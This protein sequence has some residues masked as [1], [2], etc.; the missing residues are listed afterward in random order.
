MCLQLSDRWASSWQHLA[1][2]CSV[3]KV[4]DCTGTM[5]LTGQICTK[6]RW[7]AETPTM[8]PN[9]PMTN[10]ALYVRFYFLYECSLMYCTRLIVEFS[11]VRVTYKLLALHRTQGFTMDSVAGPACP[12]RRQHPHLSSGSWSLLS[13]MNKHS[14]W[15]K[16]LVTGLFSGGAKASVKSPANSTL[17]TRSLLFLST[18]T[19]SPC[20]APGS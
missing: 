2:C 10:R 15:I 18:L 14:Y 20:R 6:A 19:A 3:T 16:Q 4:A 5:L 17:F 12:S 8:P 11:N 1:G 9:A 13:Q 7:E